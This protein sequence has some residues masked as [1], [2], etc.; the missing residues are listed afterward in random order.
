[1]YYQIYDAKL[2][3]ATVVSPYQANANDIFVY[4]TDFTV[5]ISV[6]YIFF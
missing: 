6:G 2:Y 1:M 4:T 3:T 5:L